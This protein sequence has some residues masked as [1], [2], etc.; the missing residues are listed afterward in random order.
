MESFSLFEET[1]FEIFRDSLT[2]DICQNLNSRKFISQNFS[3]TP[4]FLYRVFSL[5]FSAPVYRTLPAC[6]HLGPNRGPH[7]LLPGKRG[8]SSGALQAG[9]YQQWSAVF[10][11][12]KYPGPLSGRKIRFHHKGH[13]ERQ[14]LWRALVQS[15]NAWWPTRLAVWRCGWAA[16][17]LYANVAA[18]LCGCVAVWL[19]ACAP[20]WLCGNAAAWRCGR[21]AVCLCC[22]VAVRL[23]GNMAVWRYD[24]VAGWLMSHWSQ[25]VRSD[26]LSLYLRQIWFSEVSLNTY[27]A[28]TM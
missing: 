10:I 11:G 24:W 22:C 3:E 26:V 23:C 6:N 27:A 21:M 14:R 13:P 2:R 19:C 5:S 9:Y 20:E 7:R 12:R 17:W 15:G 4:I 25:K 8:Q 18:C 28:R 16:M 1:N